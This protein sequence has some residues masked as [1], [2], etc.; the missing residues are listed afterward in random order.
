MAACS[1][2]LILSPFGHLLIRLLGLSVFLYGIGYGVLE[3]A[4]SKGTNV[5]LSGK[6]K[7]VSSVIRLASKASILLAGV[8]IGYG[9]RDHQ[10]SQ[11]THTY[12][13]VVVLERYT[14]QRFKVQPAMS[15]SGVWDTCSPQD[16]Q[17]GQKMDW[18][19]IEQNLGCK[20]IR[21]QHFYSNSQGE[22]LNASIQMR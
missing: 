21:Y 1:Y 8:A 16:W 9:I 22:R 10:L 13:D 11:N 5:L 7:T 4:R 17:A 14:P 12:W 20:T 6:N 19:T 3:Y 2:L 15:V 18:V